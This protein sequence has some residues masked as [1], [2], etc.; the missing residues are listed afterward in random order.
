[1]PKRR[2]NH[3][4]KAFKSGSGALGRADARGRLPGRALPRW[5]VC[6]G[7]PKRGQIWVGVVWKVDPHKKERRIW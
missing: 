2:N 7:A 6:R 1:M 4:P 5:H 3:S